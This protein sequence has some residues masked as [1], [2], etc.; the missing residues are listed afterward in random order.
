MSAAKRVRRTITQQVRVS[1]Q[2][3]AMIDLAQL[4]ELVATAE[5]LP[6]TARVYAKDLIKSPQE[7]EGAYAFRGMSIVQSE[8]EELPHE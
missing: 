4:R 7:G 3:I 2:P 1:V 8:L 6:G 5:E